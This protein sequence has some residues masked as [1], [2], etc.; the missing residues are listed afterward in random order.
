MPT[1]DYTHFKF[2]LE[3]FLLKALAAQKADL[4]KKVDEGLPKEKKELTEVTEELK[5][6]NL[7]NDYPL[8]YAEPI[9]ENIGYNQ[10]LREVK[11]F[12]RKNT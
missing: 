9:K 11:A 1:T 12:L 8:D 5:K 6:Y 7:E 2:F 10:A 3:Q 4:L